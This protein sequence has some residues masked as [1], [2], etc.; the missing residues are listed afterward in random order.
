LAQANFVQAKRHLPVFSKRC[1]AMRV[2]RCLTA[3]TLLGLGVA[4]NFKELDDKNWG[5]ATENRNCFIMFQAP[6]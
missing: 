6:W 1:C 3:A 4:S 5:S 2:L